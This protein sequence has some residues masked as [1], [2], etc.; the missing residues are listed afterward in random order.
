MRPRSC[1]IHCCWSPGQLDEKRFGPP[2]PVQRMPDGVVQSGKRRS[3]YVQQLR[4][5]PPTILE[6]F[7]LPAMNPNCLSRSDS[8]VALQALPPVKRHRAVRE[9]AGQL[10]A[11]A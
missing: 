1:A 7:D 4:K 9:L 2:D 5:D 8:L 10:A 11:R 6:N 3:V